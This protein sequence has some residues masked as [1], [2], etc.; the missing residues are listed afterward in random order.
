MSKM[1]LVVGGKLKQGHFCFIFDPPLKGHCPKFSHFLVTPPPRLCI[2]I[3]EY[4]I[5]ILPL[6]YCLISCQSALGTQ[7]W[8]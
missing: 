2:N 1:M 8:N 4:C 6:D 7:D 3:V 5:V